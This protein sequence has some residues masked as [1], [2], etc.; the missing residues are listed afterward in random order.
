MQNLASVAA[1]TLAPVVSSALNTYLGKSR[2]R[3]RRGKNKQNKGR[4]QF[5]QL[6][7]APRGGQ[8]QSGRG[9]RRRGRGGGPQS[10]NSGFAQPGSIGNKSMPTLT[11]LP[12]AVSGRSFETYFKQLGNPT[13]KEW[14][15]GVRYSGCSLLGAMQPNTTNNSVFNAAISQYIFDGTYDLFYDLYPAATHDNSGLVDFVNRIMA[16]HPG[17]IA[18]LQNECYAWGRYAFRSL[19]I[20]SEAVGPT[21][22]TGGFTAALSH[23]VSWPLC[24]DQVDSLGYQDVAQLGNHITANFYE[25]F[26]LRADDFKGDR[27]WTTTIPVMAVVPSG[28]NVSS[29]YLWPYI[30]A[31]YQY[32]W[33]VIANTGSAG[34]PQ[35]G[36]RGNVYIS[37]VVDFY[38]V[39]NDASRNMLPTYWNDGP[40]GTLSDKEKT[41]SKTIE[42]PKRMRTSYSG[43]VGRNQDRKLEEKSPPC[44]V[45]KLIGRLQ[46]VL[47]KTRERERK[48][49]SKDIS[50]SS[51]KSRKDLEPTPEVFDKLLSEVEHEL[52]LTS[53]TPSTV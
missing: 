4:N 39:K 24:E 11:G 7:S 25:N 49:G 6:P 3:G 44:E 20:H 28:G 27:T 45:Y 30:D 15:Q 1:Q 52:E 50:R 47:D 2:R 38:S 53:V 48:E 35:A 23:D 34:S 29:S 46:K 14:G 36:F 31:S 8:R 22:D 21:T 37:Y 41:H 18:R 13:H 17:L 12:T 32:F 33:S 42:L 10:Y 19:T 51:S 43:A 5:P 40:T 26:A 16:I 9:G